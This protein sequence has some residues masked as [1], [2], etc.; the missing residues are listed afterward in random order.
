MY[1]TGFFSR[2]SRVS[3]LRV[4]IGISVQH[5][6]E[7]VVFFPGFWAINVPKGV[8]FSFKIGG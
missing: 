7:F 5:L 3:K 4:W 8:A 1:L 2:H 6:R